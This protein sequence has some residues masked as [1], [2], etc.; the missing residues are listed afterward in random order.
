MSRTL[1]A[2]LAVALVLAWL[3]SASSVAL[4][5]SDAD[6]GPEY[7]KLVEQALDEFQRGNWD[8]AGALFEQ[9]NRIH[10]NARTLRG[11][12]FAAFESRRYVAALTSLRAALTST[13]NPLTPEQRD[14][15]RAAI[16]RAEHY[17]AQLEITVV[18]DSAEVIVNDAVVASVDGRR[19]QQLDPGEVQVRA[20]AP[21]YEPAARTLRLTSGAQERLELRLTPVSESTTATPT[22]STAATSPA[23]ANT[24]SGPHFGV[25]KW[26]VLGAGGLAL[27]GGAVSHVQREVSIGHYN[28]DD[29]CGDA[30]A[31]ATQ[32]HHCQGFKDDVDSATTRMTIGYAVGGVL[33]ATAVVLFVLEGDGSSEHA[34]R[35]CAIGLASARCAFRF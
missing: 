16:T 8:E 19:L 35:S 15:V 29:A 6:G 33:A 30:H 11:M 3:A 5:Q 18:P 14:E 17:V 12:G 7:R 20:S 13:V 2:R 1:V 28:D 22:A 26:V 10:P 32:K 23:S 4:A 21:G 24:G 34:T 27:I 9:A 25:W 31:T